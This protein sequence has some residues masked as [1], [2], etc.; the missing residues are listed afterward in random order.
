MNLLLRN[1][2]ISAI[3]ISQGSPSVRIKEPYHMLCSDSDFYRLTC[4][5]LALNPHILGTAGSSETYFVSSLKKRGMGRGKPLGR[6][7][8]RVGKAVLAPKGYAF[9][10]LL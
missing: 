7:N 6:S 9:L 4:F 3:A 2:R 1:V 8:S 10:T 5:H